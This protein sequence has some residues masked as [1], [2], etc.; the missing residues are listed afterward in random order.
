MKKIQKVRNS[1]RI[2]RDI[3]GEGCTHTFSILV[4]QSSVGVPTFSLVYNTFRGGQVPLEVDKP[5]KVIKEALEKFAAANSLS[6]FSYAQELAENLLQENMFPAEVIEPQRSKAQRHWLRCPNHGWQKI[7]HWD[8]CQLGTFYVNGTH[9][10]RQHEFAACGC[11]F[12]SW[13]YAGGNVRRYQLEMAAKVDEE[14]EPDY[15]AKF[16]R[17]QG[18]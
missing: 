5:L 16:G 6:C 1:N 4:R 7:I 14:V 3:L 12:D 18:G 8:S 10:E 13:Y 11:Q 9:D 15:Y 17:P 2:I